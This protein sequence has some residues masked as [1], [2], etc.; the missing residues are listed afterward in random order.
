MAIFQHEDLSGSH[1]GLCFNGC[2]R[3]PVN[4]VQ[5]PTS[6]TRCESKLQG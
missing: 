1:V 6:L 2:F 5:K 4:L 3:S